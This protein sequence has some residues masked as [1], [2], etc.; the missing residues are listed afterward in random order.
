MRLFTLK[1]PRV[2]NDG[3]DYASALVAFEAETIAQ[4]GGCTIGNT[5]Q[6]SWAGPD[7][8]IYRD[9]VVPFEIACDAATFGKLTAKAFDLFPDQL[10]LFAA[11]G[12]D[13]MILDRPHTANDNAPTY[14][15]AEDVA[16]V[17]R[18]L[19]GGYA[20]A[21]WTVDTALRAVRVAKA[22]GQPT[23]TAE[24]QLASALRQVE[25]LIPGGWR[26]PA[27]AEVHQLSA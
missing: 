18:R 20:K 16:D 23:A 6:G 11:C 13:A 3:R 7:G 19:S 15:A 17:L 21:S 5:Q 24:A 9:R 26:A 12:A 4:A 1:L 8:T 25:N 22:N 2:G 27:P 10:A 14:Q